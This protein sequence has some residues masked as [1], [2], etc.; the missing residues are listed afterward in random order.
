MMRSFR[1]AGR[2]TGEMG[3]RFGFQRST[4]SVKPNPQLRPQL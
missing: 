3:M 4:L 1:F 2:K